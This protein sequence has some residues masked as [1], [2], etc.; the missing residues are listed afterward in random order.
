MDEI[1]RGPKTMWRE[2]ALHRRTALCKNTQSDKGNS[3]KVLIEGEDFPGKKR[4]KFFC[5]SDYSI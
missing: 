5:A 1:A 4:R 3:I 2:F